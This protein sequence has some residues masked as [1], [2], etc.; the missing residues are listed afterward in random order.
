M[1]DYIML[2]F[3]FCSI[4]FPNILF[5]QH[6][7]LESF[8]A[9]LNNEEVTLKWTIKSGS[10]CN[11]VRIHRSTDSI[12]YS[13]IGLRAGVCGS[14]ENPVSYSF[15]DE[16][17]APNTFNYYKLELGLQGFSDP[18]SIEYIQLNNDQYQVRPNPIKN[19]ATIYFYNPS[20]LKNTFI[21]YNISG[22]ILLQYENI[23]SEE[24]N[25]DLANKLGGGMYYFKIEN[26]KG[27]IIKGSVSII[28]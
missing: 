14:S 25:I 17:P 5:A 21:L 22:N 2:F 27:N 26:E 12:N 4:L 8:N 10:T 23:T 15:I 6:P 11:G 13:Q 20:N 1:Q 19:K 9:L 3:R 24:I 18:I 16:S 7:I 28:Q